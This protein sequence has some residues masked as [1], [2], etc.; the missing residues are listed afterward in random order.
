[1]MMMMMPYHLAL[2]VRREFNVPTTVGL[3]MLMVAAVDVYHTQLVDVTHS[4]AT[5]QETTTKSQRTIV[6]RQSQ[7][8]HGLCFGRI[9]IRTKPLVV[10]GSHLLFLI[11]LSVAAYTISRATLPSFN[12]TCRTDTNCWVKTYWISV[13]CPFHIIPSAV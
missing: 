3:L 9:Q 13:T 10:V 8:G 4:S 6:P 12:A 2:H 11:L 1:M 7:G 5:E